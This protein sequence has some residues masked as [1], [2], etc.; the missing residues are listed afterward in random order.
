MLAVN[1][2]QFYAHPFWWQQA[3]KNK[4]NLQVLNEIFQSSH[5][6]NCLDLCESWETDLQDN[7]ESNKKYIEFLH[8]EVQ[9]DQMAFKEKRRFKG[10]FYNR[11]M[12]RI[13]QSNAI[14]YPSLLPHCPFRSIKFLRVD[15]TNSELFLIALAYDHC[16]D[17]LSKELN[18]CNPKRVRIPQFIRIVSAIIR[19]TGS[20]RTEGAM[21]KMIEKY[22]S[23]RLMNPIKYY[24][25]HKKAPAIVHEII[26]V[27]S[28]QLP[29]DLEKGSLPAIWEK[30]KF[31]AERVCNEYSRILHFIAAQLNI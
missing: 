20:F 7:N 6:Q 17:A 11:F 26:Q 4:E 10:R 29:K 21:E 8:E 24:F 28:G 19:T 14:L 12:E 22:K 25:Q 3:N 2:L 23:H 5:I 16:Y 18:G 31:S 1:F 13:L 9:T 15:P 27:N 30:Y